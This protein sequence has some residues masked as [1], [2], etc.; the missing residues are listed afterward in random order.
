[1]EERMR[2][3]PKASGTIKPSHTYLSHKEQEIVGRV[4]EWPKGRGH[5]YLS[6]QQQGV[7]RPERGADVAVLA[8]PHVS[9]IG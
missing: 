3:R 5:T 6:H 1:M 4:R 8:R 9:A 7:S 2:E